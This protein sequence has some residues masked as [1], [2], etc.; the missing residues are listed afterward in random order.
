MDCELKKGDPLS[1]HVIK[2]IGYVQALDW[3]VFPLLDELAI[4]A[5]QGSLP[6]SYGTFISNY[7]MHGMDKKLI[8]SHGMLN[9]AEQ[10]IK[11]G[12]HQVLM[13]Q[14]SAKLTIICMAWIRSSL[15]RMGCSM[16][17]SKILRKAHIKC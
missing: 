14:K 7:H 12:T 11:K 16:W 10:D 4:D 2:M 17:Q 9:V 5:V 8:E 13:V 6:P 15:N 1:P 3:L